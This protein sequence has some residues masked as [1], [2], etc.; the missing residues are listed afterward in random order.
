[1]SQKCF[2]IWETCISIR[3][4]KKSIKNICGQWCSMMLYFAYFL[5]SIRNMCAIL[6]GMKNENKFEKL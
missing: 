6:Q 5:N 3:F 4:E 2:I 1:M